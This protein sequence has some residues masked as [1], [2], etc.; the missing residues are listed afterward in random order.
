MLIIRDGQVIEEM[1]NKDVSQ[2]DIMESILRG[3]KKVG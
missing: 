3:G 1:E 2:K